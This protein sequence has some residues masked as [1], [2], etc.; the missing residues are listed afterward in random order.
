MGLGPADFFVRAHFSPIPV[1]VLVGAAAWYAWSV[2]RLGRRGRTWPGPR[3]AAFA[4]ACLLFAVSALSGVYAFDPTNFSAF[5]SQY[6][7]AG[8]LAP[9]L[10]ALSAPITLAVQS[11]SATPPPPAGWIR[12]RPVKALTHPLVTWVLFAATVF[13]LYFTRGLLRQALGGGAIQ[14]LVL[15]WVLAAGWLFFLPLVDVDPIPIRLG[16]WA[17]VAYA[18]L[19]IP[20][21]T[22]MGMGVE[23][24]LAPITTTMSTDSLH[25]GGA[26]VWVAANGVAIC[27][28]LAVFVQWL[29][30]D[31]R[32]AAQ[33]DVAN[34]DAAARQLALW[35]ASR[36]A[37]ARA[38]R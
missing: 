13:V 24:Q 20:V 27:V 38:A 10:L 29:R 1:A 18:L 16:P 36:E 34:E 2:R 17:R 37:A 8:L 23:S 5:A 30:A 31:E 25:L 19:T 35:R 28:A 15:L 21:F 6:I 26:V 9:A 12:S 33:H 22:I 32:R 14:Q 7:L 4:G 11:S 3:S